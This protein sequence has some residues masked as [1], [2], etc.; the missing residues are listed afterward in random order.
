MY[1]NLFKTGQAEPLRERRILPPPILRRLVGGIVAG[2]P[3]ASRRDARRITGVISAAHPAKL[4]GNL[5]AIAGSLLNRFLTFFPQISETFP[6]QCHRTSTGVT[7][8][9]AGQSPVSLP[10]YARH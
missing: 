4:P 2:L 8:V 10:S 5:R 6:P 1:L 9:I 7:G 3:A